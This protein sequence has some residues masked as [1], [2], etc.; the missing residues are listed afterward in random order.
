VELRR[1]VEAAVNDVSTPESRGLWF[2][3]DRVE[4]SGDP[5]T[6]LR[7]WATLHFL[8]REKPYCCGEPGCHLPMHCSG[9]AAVEDHVR[10]AMRLT[11]RVSIE[12]GDGVG[13]CYH[14]GTLMEWPDG[15][16]RPMQESGA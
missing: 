5:P 4:A 11:D 6:R 7:I 13:V 2:C 3:V 15:P 8:P 9:L 16:P 10:T 1:L 14:P 12:F